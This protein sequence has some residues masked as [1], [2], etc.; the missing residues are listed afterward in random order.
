MNGDRKL[1]ERDAREEEENAQG[2]IFLFDLEWSE[3]EEER[4][5]VV[6]NE[7]DAIVAVIVEQTWELTLTRDEMECSVEKLE[8]GS[9]M[10]KIGEGESDPPKPEKD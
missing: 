7:E 9:R 1:V 2:E 8:N 6:R 5:R 4:I 10:N 3:G